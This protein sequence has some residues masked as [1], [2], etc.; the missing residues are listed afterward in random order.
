ML[1]ALLGALGAANVLMLLRALPGA[2]L[3]GAR[4]V[5]AA[6]SASSVSGATA[7]TLHSSG[8]GR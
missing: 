2:R 6:A 7:L 5:A 4:A 3:G 1:G 8:L